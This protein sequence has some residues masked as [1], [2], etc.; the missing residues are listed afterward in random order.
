[1]SEMFAGTSIE[2]LDLSSFNTEKVEDMTKMFKKC[3]KL[4]KLNLS[5]F[6]VSP[7]TGIEQMFRCCPCLEKKNIKTKDEKLLAQFDKDLLAGDE[8]EE[9][10]EEQ[11]EEEV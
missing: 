6:K 8:P 9:A 3:E 1:M 7:D 4:K 5:N 11:G 2:S 10:N